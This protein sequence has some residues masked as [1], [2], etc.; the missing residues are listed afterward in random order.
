MV[1]PDSPSVSMR[2]HDGLGRVVRTVHSGILPAGVTG[3]G[4]DGRNDDGMRIAAGMVL[5]SLG[6]GNNNQST[7]ALLIR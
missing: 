4:W 6:S 5:V 1:Q 7:K 3:F 2:I